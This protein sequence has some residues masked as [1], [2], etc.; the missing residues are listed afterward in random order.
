MASIRDPANNN[1]VS[2]GVIPMKVSAR[3]VL[4]GKVKSVVEGMVNAE[5][6]VELAGGQEV[7]AV[8]TKS[9]AQRLGVK[10]GKEI[11]AIIKATSVMLG[12]D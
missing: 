7:V 12:A 1:P 10:V 4:Q 3:N 6:V 9:S 2:V 8:I 11:Y 5:V